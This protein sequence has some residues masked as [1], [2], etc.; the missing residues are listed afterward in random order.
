MNRRDDDPPD[1][2][3]DLFTEVKEMLE[4]G[5]LRPVSHVSHTHRCDQDCGAVL[6]CP[7]DDRCRV[8]GA[9]TCPSC[10]DRIAELQAIALAKTLGKD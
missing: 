9:W 8:R 4:R 1:D 10:E 6:T 2:V 7:D 3:D 5:P